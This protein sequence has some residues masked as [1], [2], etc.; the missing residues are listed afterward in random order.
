M[1]A[2]LRTLPATLRTGLRRGLLGPQALAF[3]PAA[4]LA[5]FW[6]GGEPLLLVVALGMP[7]LFLLVGIPWDGGERSVRTE[8]ADIIDSIAAGRMA[9]QAL[10]R[11]RAANLASACLLIEVDGLDHVALQADTATVDALRDL[12][13]GRLRKALR[14][15]D[16]A[17]RLGE[18]RFLILLGPSL[19]LDLEALLQ[20]SGR[21]QNAVEEPASVGDAMRYLSASIG[22]C[23]SLRLA[24]EAAGKQL[25][26]AAHVALEE[27]KANGP[28]AIRAWS[29]NMRQAHIEQTSLRNEVDRALSNGQ[30]QPWFQPQICTSTGAISGVEALARWI[31]PER[32]IVPPAQFLRVLE[33]AGRM[34]HLSEVILQ[35]SLTALRSW[36]QAG[37]DIP[38]VSVNFSDP[39]LRDP[40]LVDRIQWELDRFGLTAERLGIEVLETV[41]AGAPEGIVARNI[42]ELG[43]IGCHIDLDDFGTGHASITSLRRFKVHR[44]KIDRS[45]VTR[46]DRDEEQHRMLAA[47]LGLADR[48]GLETLAEGVE[49]VGEHALLAQ[50]GCDHVQGFGIARPMPADKLIKW[51]HDHADRIADAQKLGRSSG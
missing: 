5:A 13:L 17:V 23:G 50:L 4:A 16:E 45:F 24:N 46:I 18:N 29:E 34:D 35:H 51:A 26:E 7:G 37:I 11:A 2:S 12:T 40:R 10:D 47:V 30:I 43:K 14:R 38:R 8:H 49:S 42:V 48:L 39:E 1:L 15:D 3:L 31:H 32:G 27:A 33:D 36:D 21:L 20:L 19:R 9:Q 44:L 41:I 22:F 28:S 25:L 6:L